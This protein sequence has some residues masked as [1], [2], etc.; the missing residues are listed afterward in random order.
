[1]SLGSMLKRL[2]PRS[3]ATAEFP[4]DAFDR[5]MR[6]PPSPPPSA[7]AAAPA[8]Q[9]DAGVLR[10]SEIVD[11]K[12]RIAGYRFDLQGADGAPGSAGALVDALRRADV[13][14]FAQRRLALIPVTLEAWAG[15]GFRAFVAPHT[16]FLVSAPPAEHAPDAV[17]AGLRDMKAAG[18]R[19]ALQGVDASARF[20]RPLQLCDLVVIDFHAYPL[21]A[22][23]ALTESMKLSYPA[24][25][26]AVENVASWP[27]RRLCTARGVH[28]CLGPFSVLPDAD[29]PAGELSQSRLVLIEML[30][31]LRSDAEVSALAAVAKRDPAV[32]LQVVAMANS[33]ASGLAAPVASFDQAMLVLGREQLYRWIA[34][35]MFRTGSTRARDEALLE[36]AL[37]RARFLELLALDSGARGQADELFLVGLLSLMDALLG[38]PLPRVLERLSLP[39]AVEDVLL[40]SE[41]AYA[42]HLAL[43]IALQHGS[44][45]QWAKHAEALALDTARVRAAHDAA[46]EWAEGAMFGLKAA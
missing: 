5:S 16:A 22:F 6:A 3:P 41:G 42:R 18:A 7:A 33:P 10:R 30:N 21:S 19:V 25:E 45:A 20:G 46:L 38:Q 34:V 36:L 28:Y 9:P 40:R 14:R 43:A 17:A 27:E 4:E 8:G 15:G 44:D 2:L 39:G 1:M 12:S 23:D 13:V 35:S 37:T 26:L 11:A 32:A 31:L 24:V 29:E